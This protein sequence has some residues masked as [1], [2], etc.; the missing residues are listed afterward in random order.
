MSKKKTPPPIL[1]A[2]FNASGNYEHMKHELRWIKN[3]THLTHSCDQSFMPANCLHKCCQFLLAH[4]WSS[5]P[6]HAVRSNC[7]LPFHLRLQRRPKGLWEQQGYKTP[8]RDKNQTKTHVQHGSCW[9]L[10]VPTA[11]RPNPRNSCSPGAALFSLTTGRG[12]SQ[13][14]SVEH[15]ARSLRDAGSGAALPWIPSHM[16]PQGAHKTRPGGGMNR[17]LSYSNGLRSP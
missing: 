15:M 8:P 3:S 1:R 10:G 17:R 5:N 16:R 14:H 12:F 6:Q 4:E 13:W 9:S 11:V 2:V 7:N